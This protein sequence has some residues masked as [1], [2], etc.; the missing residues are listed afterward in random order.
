M[1][2]YDSI[3]EKLRKIEALFAGAATQG[4]RDAAG[5]ARERILEKLRSRRETEKPE[6]FRFS[7]DNPWSRSLLVALLRRYEIK[8]Y[9]YRG[10]RRTTIMA[11]MPRSF[12][13][14]TL[15]P[16]FVSLNQVL[17]DHLG[18]LANRIIGQAIS[19][20]VSEAPEVPGQIEG[21]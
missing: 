11:R 1:N 12:V 2:E 3:L 10:Q 4:E 18:E 5:A 15:W 20:D 7:H 19:P 8:P 14:D 17:I 21:T 6:E 13:N 9:R 16:E